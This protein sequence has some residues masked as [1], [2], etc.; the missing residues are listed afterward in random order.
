M[1]LNQELLAVV[2]T[3]AALSTMYVAFRFVDAALA[4]PRIPIL[5]AAAILKVGIAVGAMIGAFLGLNGLALARTGERLIPQELSLLLL[6]I[7]LVAPAVT[8][9]PLLRLLRAMTA[10]ARRDAGT[11]GHR[12][13]GDPPAPG[14]D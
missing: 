8:E 4:K 14:G 10:E 13:A 5:T 11:P 7:A 12:R 1:R 9:L 2:F 3:L 6:A